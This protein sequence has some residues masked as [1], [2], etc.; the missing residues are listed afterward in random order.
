MI[1]GDDQQHSKNNSRADLLLEENE[2]NGDS[3]ISLD[4]K[5]NAINEIGNVSVGNLKIAKT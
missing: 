3:Q 2:T 4:I 1:G 5:T